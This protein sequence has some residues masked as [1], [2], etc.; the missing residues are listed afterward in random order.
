M[1]GL[2][3]VYEEIA[4]SLHAQV[5]TLSVCLSVSLPC[6]DTARRQPSTRQQR[7]FS[8]NR[9]RWHPELGLSSPRNVRCNV[10]LLKPLGL[11]LCYGGL[12]RP[13]LL[14]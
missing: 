12:S 8:I 13:L 2:V 11:V 14:P 1:M 10:L 4:E 5:H 9:P 3:P 6:E 7:A